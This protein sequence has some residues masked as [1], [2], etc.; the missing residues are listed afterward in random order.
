MNNEVTKIGKIRYIEPNDF[1]NEKYT[2]NITQVYED[3]SISVDL[4]VKVPKRSGVINDDSNFTEN[5]I[6]NNS[7]SFFSGTDK[8]M[9]D[10][11]GTSM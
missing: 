7:Y 4:I 10:A 2:D 1:L 9:T 3:Y 5:I 11:P 6:A 8:Y